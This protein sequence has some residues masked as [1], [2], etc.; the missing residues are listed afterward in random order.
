MKQVWVNIISN[1]Q[2]C[3]F[4]VHVMQLNM[5]AHNTEI[6]CDDFRRYLH[7]HFRKIK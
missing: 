1:I 7:I 3:T 4:T 6:K 2:Y 5:C